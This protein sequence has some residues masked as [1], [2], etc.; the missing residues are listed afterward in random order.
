MKTLAAAALLAALSSGFADAQIYP[1][2][3]VRLIVPYPPG[4][5]TDLVAR[6]I[7]QKL[8]DSL[9]R[10]VLIDNR[11][12][13]NGLIGTEAIAKSTPDGYTVGM[14]TPGP[15]TVAKSLYGNLNYDPEKDLVPVIL[16]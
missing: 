4:G 12:G 16:A 14:A 6:F 5:G 8:G 11:A 1:T 3:P 13:A 7:C 2:K 10:P 9:G 15:V